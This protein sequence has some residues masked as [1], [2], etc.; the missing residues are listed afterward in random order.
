MKSFLDISGMFAKK[1]PTETL[2]RDFVCD[3]FKKN[4]NITLDRKDIHVQKNSID[5]RISPIIRAKLA[6]YTA[7][8]VEQLNL[9]LKEKKSNLTIKIMR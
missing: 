8:C 6:P 1:I 4:Q 5:L 2:I 9:H 3:F 7:E